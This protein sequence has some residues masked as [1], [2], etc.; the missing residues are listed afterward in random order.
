MANIINNNFDNLFVRI[1]RDEYVDFFL[2]KDRTQDFQTS[3]GLKEDCLISYIDTNDPDCVFFTD[4][5]SKERYSWDEAI[6]NGLTLRNIGFTGVDNGLILFD[7]DKITNEEFIKIFTGSSLSI[8]SDDYRLRL[9]MISGNTKEFIYPCDIIYENGIQ[10]IKMNGGFYQGFFKADKNKYEILPSSIEKEWAFEIVLKRE[11]YDHPMGVI[12][13]DKYPENKGIF[14]YIGTR[15]ENKW[16]RYYTLKNNCGLYCGL[17]SYFD[18]EYNGDAYEMPQ[19]NIVNSDW[20][21]DGDSFTETVEQYDNNDGYFN[22]SYPEKYKTGST[23]ETLYFDNEYASGD[24]IDLSYQ[25]NYFL[26][27]E[28][29]KNDIKIPEDA[30]FKTVNGNQITQQGIFEIKTDNKFIFFNRTPTGFTVNN[31][32][33]GDVVVLT[34]ISENEITDN[35]FITFNRTPTGMTAGCFDKESSNVKKYDIISDITRNAIAFRIDDNGRVGYRYLDKSC[36]DECEYAI[37]EEYS[38]NGVVELSK[39][40]VIDI[41]IKTLDNGSG[42]NSGSLKRKMKIYIYVN[43]QLKLIS[44][45]LNCINLKDLNDTYDKQEGVP[46]NISIGG[47]SQGLIE[48]IYPNYYS[49]SKNTLPIEKYF[50]G[51]FIGE[52]KSFK[53][54]NCPLNYYEIDNNVDFEFKS[55]K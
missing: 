30:E 25:N 55:I 2:S 24:Y 12:L 44:R 18:E 53:F 1:N 10:T 48:A 54:Y 42:N 43:G 52:F 21:I 33:D 38:M 15:S 16:Y 29:V 35:Y 3:N 50:A 20:F 22:D 51:S 32:E 34:G 31:F 8:S 41:R 27:K 4:L 6:N 37:T 5:I 13:N 19:D 17:A 23:N 47:G 26:D 14:L 9:K 28:Y 45:E 7:K 40:Y 49:Q 36:D 11:D 46:Y 39:W